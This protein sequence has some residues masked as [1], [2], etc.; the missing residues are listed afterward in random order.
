MVGAGIA[1]LGACVSLQQVGL[2]VTLIEA[3]PVIGGHAHCVQFKDVAV[4]DTSYMVF[5]ELT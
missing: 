3:E 5:N 1:G 2:D 4:V